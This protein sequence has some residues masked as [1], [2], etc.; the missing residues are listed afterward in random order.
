MRG[1]GGGA[2]AFILLTEPRGTTLLLP[3]R[4]PMST[5]KKSQEHDLGR[6]QGLNMAM[7]CGSLSVV[8]GKWQLDWDGVN[9]A[10]DGSWVVGMWQ[11]ECSS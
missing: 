7:G 4:I 8:V 10:I 3:S 11:F 1:G 2:W 5:G 6:R 9:M